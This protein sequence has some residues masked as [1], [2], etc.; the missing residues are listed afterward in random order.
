MDVFVRLLNVLLMVAMPLALGVILVRRSRVEWRIFLLGAGAFIGSQ[1]FHLP[2]NG[3]VLSPLTERLGLPGLDGGVPLLLYAILFGLSAGVFEEVAR[4]LVYR[5][6][7]RESR[8]KWD[9]LM[10]GTGHGGLESILLGGLAGLA[11]FQ[12]ITYRNA[13]LSAVVPPEQLELARAQLEAY[14]TAPWYAVLLSAAERF[15]TICFHLS[16]A[17]L[18]LQAFVRRNP[19]WLAVAIGW[20][21]I[22]DTLAVFALV[23]WGA[24]VSEGFVGLIALL[25]LGI[26]YVLWRR[27][28]EEQEVP[29]LPSVDRKIRAREPDLELEELPD[30]RLEDSR[31]DS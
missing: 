8:T 3:Y 22:L 18:V 21:A 27:D 28:G 19:V 16:A 17:L 6:W 11:L 10:F 2:F 5:I 12:A 26:V 9:G 25:S 30:G 7:M 20:H 24:Y 4:Y 29:S 23:T 1:I 14:W 15:F 31:Y 13:D